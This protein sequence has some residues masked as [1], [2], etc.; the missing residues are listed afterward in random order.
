MLGVDVEPDENMEEIDENVD[1][2]VVDNGLYGQCCRMRLF[3]VDRGNVF[4]K[5]SIGLMWKQCLK[6]LLFLV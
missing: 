3:S 4:Y 2:A 1:E 6:S 5:P